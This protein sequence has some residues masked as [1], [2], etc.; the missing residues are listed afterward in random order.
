MRPAHPAPAGRH[1]DIRSR[2][3]PLARSPRAAAARPGS[4]A[5]AALTRGGEMVERVGK[6]RARNRRQRID[7]TRIPPRAGWCARQDEGHGRRGKP[8]QHVG[9]H[10][11]R[12]LAAT[13]DEDADRLRLRTPGPKPERTAACTHANSACSRP[14]AQFFLAVLEPGREHQRLA[15]LARG[16]RPWPSLPASS[17]RA[18]TARRRASGHSRT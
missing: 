2:G 5:R 11:L 3:T 16:P 6:L 13:V 15:D 12:R 17:R 18:R 4:S 1:R 8:R 14:G 7:R 9:L 10:L